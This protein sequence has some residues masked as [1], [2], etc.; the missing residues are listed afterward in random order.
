MEAFVMPFLGSG[1]FRSP[2]RL[3]LAFAVCLSLL[4]VTRPAYADPISI[5]MTFEGLT[6]STP[7]PQGGSG[8][9][10]Q[11][12]GSVNLTE[13]TPELFPGLGAQPNANFN[14]FCMDATRDLKGTDTYD[15]IEAT[16]GTISSWDSVPNIDGSSTVATEI[17]ELFGTFFGGLSIPNNPAFSPYGGSVTAQYASFQDAIWIL[18]GAKMSDPLANYFVTHLGTTEATNVVIFSSTSAG[19]DGQNQIGVLE[20]CPAPSGAL[21]ALIGFVGLVGYQYRQRGLLA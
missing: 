21:L 14:T 9:V 10:F 11:F 3:F 12:Q 19:G 4:A 7:G 8:G 17:L 20:P 6:V 18:E 1:P 13:G 5:S 2:P 15:V 16:P